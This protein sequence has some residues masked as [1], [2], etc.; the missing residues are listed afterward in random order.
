MKTYQDDGEGGLK[1]HEG[2]NLGIRHTM[3][4]DPAFESGER[5]LRPRSTMPP[6]LR[7]C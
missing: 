6:N 7:R 3:D 4:R 5:D 1:L 2:N